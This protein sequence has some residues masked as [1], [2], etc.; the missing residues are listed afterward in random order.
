MKFIIFSAILATA[1]FVYAQS[2]IWGQCGGRDWTGATSCEAGSTCVPADNNP[3][4]SQCIPD[5]QGPSLPFLGGVNTAGYDFSVAT[6]GSFNGTGVS[7]PVSQFTHFASEGVNIFRIPWQLMTPTLG[8]TI[9]SSF[10]A[11]YDAT[12]QAALSASTSPY[13]IVD[14]HNYARWNGEIIGQGGPTNDQFASIWSQLAAKYANEPHII[15]GIMNEPHDLN[16]I[17]TWAESVQVAVNAIRAAG[18]TSQHLLLPGS[19]WSSA[20]ALPTEAGPFLL[21]VTDPAGGTSKL[22]FDVHKYLD[23]D[24]SGTHA[25]CVTNNIDVLTTLVS[26]LQSNGNRQAILSETGGGNTASCETDLGQELAFVK[27]NS[28]SI[29]GFSVWAAGAFDTTYILSVTPNANGT[30]QPLWTAAVR[31]NLP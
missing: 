19:S 31:P 16:S 1:P 23:S 11:R 25:E 10:F 17:S 2:P 15:F 27:A 30:D 18:A 24:N 9:S 6:D 12:V 22:L 21:N 14:L 8:G 20:Q 29:V 3:Y 13:V 7:P 26:W 5:S 28:R 4:Y